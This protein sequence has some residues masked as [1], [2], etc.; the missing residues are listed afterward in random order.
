M[1]NSRRF[2]SRPPGAGSKISTCRGCWGGPASRSVGRLRSDKHGESAPTYPQDAIQLPPA[3]ALFLMHVAFVSPSPCRPVAL[4]TCPNSA[5]PP[6][7][8]SRQPAR[9]GCMSSSTTAFGYWLGETPPAL[10]CSPAA[11]MTGPSATRSWRVLSARSSLTGAWCARGAG[12][13]APMSG[14]TGHSTPMPRSPG[15][16]TPADSTLPVGACGWTAE[17]KLRKA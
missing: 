12:M 13:S 3:D 1:M 7:P 10:A 17:R 6:S 11:G 14:R 16:H 15:V 9:A 5:S 2:M 4:P 8:S